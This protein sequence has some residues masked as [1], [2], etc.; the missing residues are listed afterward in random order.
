MSKNQA[1]ASKQAAQ[2]AEDIDMPSLDD[3]GGFSGTTKTKKVEV[4]GEKFPIYGIYHA[5][6]NP[7]GIKVGQTVAGTYCGTESRGEDENG[8][9][10]TVQVLRNAKGRK[11]GLWNRGGM[12][13][14]NRVPVGTFVKV[15][16]AKFEPEA[17]R[18]KPKHVFE[19]EMADGAELLPPPARAARAAEGGE[20][21]A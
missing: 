15:T 4:L 21:R 7:N 16:Y 18:P 6:K 17:V 19:I 12:N 13:L 3:I 8:D 20:A 14:L 9:E 10:R 11:F 2:E 1:A 5:E